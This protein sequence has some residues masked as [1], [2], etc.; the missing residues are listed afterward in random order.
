[1]A[2]RRRRPLVVA[3]VP[4]LYHGRGYPEERSF[5]VARGVLT[6]RFPDVYTQ[7]LI[8]IGV[9]VRGRGSLYLNGTSY[10]LRVGDAYFLDMCHPHRHDPDGRL[11]NLYVHVQYEAANALAPRDEFARF[12]RPFLLLQEGLAEPVFPR[13]SAFRRLLEDAWRL[14]TGGDRYGYVLSWTRVIEAFVE[15]GR[16]CDATSPGSEDP[17]VMRNREVVARALHYIQVNAV[18][19][20]T[21]AQIASYCS[22]SPSRFS[23]VF[24]AVMHVSPIA[25]RNRVRV[26]R[27]VA[28]LLSTGKT[29]EEIAFECGFHSQAQFR[30]LLRRH[31][32]R[33]ARSLRAQ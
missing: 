11:E 6:H 21:L 8:E 26:E 15:I 4:P 33:T 25:Y 17:A 16:H 31:T 32:G 30:T 1:M 5:T 10:P 23:A 20:L 27:A 28:L 29:V 3:S 14:Y 22:L 18:H 19:P 12:I 13:A 7:P 9:V 24:S 2:L